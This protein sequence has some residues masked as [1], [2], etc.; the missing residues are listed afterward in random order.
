MA[1]AL[2]ILTSNSTRPVLDALVPAYEKS[3]GNKVTLS[4]DSAKAMVARIKGGESGDLVVLGTGALQDLAEAGHVTAA[5]RRGFAHAVVGV[6][7]RKGTPHPDIS[8]LAPSNNR[9]SRPSPSPTPCTVPAACT[10]R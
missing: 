6:G 7:V 2:K 4:A 9:C 1:I 5:S 10:S 3:S 8:S